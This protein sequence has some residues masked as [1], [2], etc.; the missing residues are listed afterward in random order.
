MSSVLN[1]I[2]EFSKDITSKVARTCAFQL[3]NATKRPISEEEIQ[4]AVKL[5]QETI[6][7]GAQNPAPFTSVYD[8]VGPI[9]YSW[10]GT[11]SVGLALLAAY[12]M[13]KVPPR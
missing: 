9:L 13:G 3:S 4:C 11:V 6:Q 5:A 7:K 1:I 8:S 10:G 2:A 12:S